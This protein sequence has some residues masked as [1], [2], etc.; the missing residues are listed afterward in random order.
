MDDDVDARGGGHLTTTIPRPTQRRASDAGRSR[1]GDRGQRAPEDRIARKRHVG[2]LFAL[3]G[4][5]VA[6]SIAAALFVLPVRTW[7]EQDREIAGL[8]NER[9]ELQSVN[10]D[11]QD[12]VERLQTDDGIRE[13]AREELGRIDGGEARETMLSSPLPRQMPDGWPY[14]QIDRI[15]ILRAADISATPDTIVASVATADPLAEPEGSV[16]AAAPE[17]TVAEEPSLTGTA[18]DA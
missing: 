6:V 3:A 7:F 1:L 9:N 17:A 10:N 15:M 14:S 16:A 18:T 2:W 11:L 13:A 12:E 5:V 8:E 4:L